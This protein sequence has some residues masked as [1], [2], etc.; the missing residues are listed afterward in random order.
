MAQGYNSRLD[1]SMGARNGRSLN[2]TSLVETSQK[3]WKKQWVKKHTQETSLQH[4]D[5][6]TI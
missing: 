2:H 3:V 4:K 5:A 6:I 1:E